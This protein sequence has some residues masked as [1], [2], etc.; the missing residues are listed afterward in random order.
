MTMPKL[1][2]LDTYSGTWLHAQPTAL[3]QLAACK[4]TQCASA[5]DPV[6]AQA[7]QQQF[8]QS[9]VG[10]AALKAVKDAKKQDAREAGGPSA[11]DWLS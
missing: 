5:A 2:V 4:P 10:R 7:R 3:L 11:R 8:E 9:A 1:H 6:Q